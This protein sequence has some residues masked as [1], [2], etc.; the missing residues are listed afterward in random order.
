MSPYIAFSAGFD[1]VT[2][3]TRTRPGNKFAAVATIFANI[4]G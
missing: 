3:F 1:P 4:A 2:M